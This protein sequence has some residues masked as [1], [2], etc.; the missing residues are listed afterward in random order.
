MHER[1]HSC[2]KPVCR[3][4][5][6]KDDV[7]PSAKLGSEGQAFTPPRNLKWAHFKSAAE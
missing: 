4:L 1:A 6:S 2:H 3:L 5:L 7:K